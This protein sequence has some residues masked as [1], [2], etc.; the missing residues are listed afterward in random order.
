MMIV[1]I[2]KTEFVGPFNMKKT[3]E[4]DQCPSDIWSIEGNKYKAFIKIGGKWKLVWIWEDA[5]NLFVKT[6]S[7]MFKEIKEKLLYHFWHD[8]NL[9]EFYR[10]YKRDKYISKIVE[11]CKGVRVMR[12]LDINYRII[13][14]ILTQ[15]SS[16]KQIRNMESC[17]RTYYGNGYSFNLKKI[18]NAS[19]KELQQKCKVGYRA[20]YIINAAKK[21]LSGELDIEQIKRTSSE[22][23]RKLLLK[24]NGIGPKVADIIL[25][26]GFGKSDAFPMDVWLKRALIR[27]YF[28]NKKVYD[29]KLREFAL[30]YFGQHA[31][32]AHLYMFY[33]ERK[34]RCLEN[35]RLFHQI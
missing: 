26:Y 1:K 18:A 16:V 9:L 33:Y 12:D 32:I 19:E 13:E 17:L 20:R 30:N 23:A 11:F 24:I 27:E 21:I 34:L 5:N 15:N 4:S 31:G 29:N 14:A 2:S 6:Q 22:G 3:L 10:K 25:L 7:N 8:Y 28:G 35:R